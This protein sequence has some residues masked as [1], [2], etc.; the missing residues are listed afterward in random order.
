M[1]PQQTSGS[2]KRGR[3][4]DER[5][6]GSSPLPNP[7]AI[8]SSKRRKLGDLGFSPSTD[9]ALKVLKS[10]LTPLSGVFG[11]GSAKNTSSPHESKEA[12]PTTTKAPDNSYDMNGIQ[13]DEESDHI[14]DVTS[15]SKTRGSRLNAKSHLV[16]STSPASKRSRLGQ[17]ESNDEMENNG[18]WGT[19]GVEEDALKDSVTPT[20]KRLKRPSRA[21]LAKPVV[22]EAVDEGMVEQP[23]SGTG[24]EGN[25]RSSGRQRRKP[26]RY[27]LE[28][29]ETIKTGP[30]SIL[31]PSKKN[32]D[33]PGKC[34]A[35]EVSDSGQDEIDL[36]FKDIPM[37]NTPQTASSAKTKR[38]QTPKKRKPTESKKDVGDGIDNEATSSPHVPDRS[39]LQLGTTKACSKS[40]PKAPKTSKKVAQKKAPIEEPELAGDDVS[41]VICGQEDSEEPNEIIFCDNCDLA[42]HQDCYGVPLIPDGDWFC[43]DCRP[44]ED[45]EEDPELGLV[46]QDED[47]GLE[48]EFIDEPML[49]IDL[50]N[51]PDIENLESHLRITQKLLLDKLTGRK[52]LKLQG[53][54]EEF[55]K[56]HQVVEQTVLVGEGNSMLVIGARGSGKTTV[57]ILNLLHFIN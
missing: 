53:L 22:E 26:R 40:A 29:A 15:M 9:K 25:G 44:E 21:L 35:F 49:N 36:G 24:A 55:Q 10:A 54:D 28:L 56:V 30:K 46:D 13:G 20:K 27:S 14:L 3:S 50:H 16:A 51:T 45:V 7:P 43:H 33:K 12:D 8:S 47:A 4:S 19:E 31:T 37:H 41:C 18:D 1:D 39:G 57:C 23:D 17:I 38:S 32:K 42:V 6:N 2:R 52:S 34:V 11:L 5:T 48:L